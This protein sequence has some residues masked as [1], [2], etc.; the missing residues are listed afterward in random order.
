MYCYRLHTERQD[1][2][3]DVTTALRG[4][5]PEST[6]SYRR[7]ARQPHAI[8]LGVY[9]VTAAADAIAAQRRGSPA[10]KVTWYTEQ[11]NTVKHRT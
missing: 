2:Q 1:L 6:C 11:Y 8:A 10:N 4:C 9:W 5:T 3:V 7:A